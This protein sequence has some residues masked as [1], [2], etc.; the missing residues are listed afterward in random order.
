MISFVIVL[1]KFTLIVLAL[2]LLKLSIL[3]FDAAYYYSIA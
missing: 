3:K 2:A 1:V